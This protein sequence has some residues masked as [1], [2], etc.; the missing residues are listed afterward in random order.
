LLF[1]ETWGVRREIGGT[2]PPYLVR[3]YRIFFFRVSLLLG[4][5]EDGPPPPFP[6]S[7]RYGG[8]R[9]FLLLDDFCQFRVGRLFSSF[10][11]WE[12]LEYCV[13]RGESSY[14]F[15]FFFQT[16]FESLSEQYRSS[17]TVYVLRS[18]SPFFSRPS[19]I[20][21]PFF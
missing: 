12:I 16:F 21:K 11:F 3:A 5:K 6:I 2:P 7:F 4:P 18:P 8:Y 9:F 17:V 10:F 13:G 14:L 20:S 15:F 19:R 1:P